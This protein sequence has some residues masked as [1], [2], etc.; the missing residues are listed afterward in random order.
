VRLEKAI[1]SFKQ[2]QVGDQVHSF[3]Q[4]DLGVHLPLHISLSAPLVLQ[5][6]DKDSFS[7]DL[8]KAVDASEARAF[9]VRTTDLAWV[10]NSDRS[11]YFLVLKL[12]KPAND[13]LNKLL[14]GC[15]ECADKWHLPLLY[16]QA[17]NEYSSGQMFDRSSA[18]HISIA[19]TLY[20]SNIDE[21]DTSS[22]KVSDNVAGIPIKFDAVFMKIGK[23]V[24]QIRLSH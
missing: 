21:E 15:N 20:S 16:D 11:R 5:T 6:P 17:G 24:T 23:S 12:E 1:N 22:R 4:T 14:R 7:N 18:F 10:P 2:W 9:T 13:D 19:W 3:L 8:K